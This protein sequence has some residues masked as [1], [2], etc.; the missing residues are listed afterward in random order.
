MN[1]LLHEL[2]SVDASVLRIEENIV[3]VMDM[4]PKVRRID[5]FSDT[6]VLLKGT[7]V[8]ENKFNPIVIWKGSQGNVGKVMT[9]ACGFERKFRPEAVKV[10]RLVDGVPT[11]TEYTAEDLLTSGLPVI[12]FNKRSKRVVLASR[13]ALSALDEAFIIRSEMIRIQKG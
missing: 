7:K 9:Y 12:V 1:Y 13:H 11:I 5:S 3:Q 8:Y 2:C 4:L 6:C 10:L